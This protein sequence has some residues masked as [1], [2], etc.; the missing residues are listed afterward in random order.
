LKRTAEVLYP[1]P[2]EAANNRDSK[3]VPLSIRRPSRT[4]ERPPGAG[5]VGRKGKEV[6]EVKAET[7]KVETVTRTVETVTV[8][9]AGKWIFRVAKTEK[10]KRS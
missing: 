9:V 8:V 1:R 10:E 7:V 3:P 5:T 2:A 6:A 4:L